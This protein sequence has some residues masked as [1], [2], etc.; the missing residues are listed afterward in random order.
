M[1]GNKRKAQ[2]MS[3]ET[4][5]QKVICEIP[6]RLPS[7]NDYIGICRKNPKYA[8][9]FKQN[10]ESEIGLYL[11]DLP[12]FEKRIAID[13]HWIEINKK[14]DPDNIASA[15]KFILDAMQ[16]EEIIKNDNWKFVDTDTGF[17]DTWSIGSENK[18]ILT[19]REEN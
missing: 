1:S 4:D 3:S 14:R 18:V 11:K 9:R 6:M 15:K 12:R 13:F 7:L 8:N 17:H 2:E 16:K 5:S 10:L 19:I